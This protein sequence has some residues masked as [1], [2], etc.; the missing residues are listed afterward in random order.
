MR[1][2]DYAGRYG[3]EEVLVVL[4][5]ADGCAADRILELHHT[6]RG[7]PYPSD[8]KVLRL[9]CSIGVAWAAHGDDWKSLLTRADAALYQA[10]RD[11][12]DRIVEG[13]RSGKTVPG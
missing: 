6:V 5:D 10:K 3:G 1:E 4:A 12:R 9:T 13:A 2:G 8:D 11:G 7:A